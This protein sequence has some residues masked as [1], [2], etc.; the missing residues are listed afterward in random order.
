M[1]QVSVI[2]MMKHWHKLEA[3][4]QG[5]PCL[6][7]EHTVAANRFSSVDRITGYRTSLPS[8]LRFTCFGFI[9]FP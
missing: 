5:A 2:Q 4:S 7:A 8:S 1:A 9:L 3:R 6:K